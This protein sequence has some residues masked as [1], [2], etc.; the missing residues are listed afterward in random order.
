MK[1]ASNACPFLFVKFSF[2]SFVKDDNY[3]YENDCTD[4]NIACGGFF[5]MHALFLRQT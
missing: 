1:R 4:D 3:S 5:F 2:L